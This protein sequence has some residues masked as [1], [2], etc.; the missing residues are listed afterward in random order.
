R[1]AG[2]RGLGGLLVLHKI[3]SWL[4]GGRLG[5]PRWEHVIVDAPAS[6]HSLP[7]LDSPRTLGALATI[8]PIAETLRTLDRRLHDPAETLVVVVTTPEELA[9]RETIEL[10]GELVERLGPP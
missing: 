4:A 5:R 2:G 8:G 6:G 7:L 3:G 9:V 10:Y 1:G